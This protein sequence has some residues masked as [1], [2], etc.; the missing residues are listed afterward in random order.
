MDTHVA[1]LRGI[2][3]GGN[4][5]IAMAE[6]RMLITSLG[7]ADVQSYIQSGN[8]VFSGGPVAASE[9][10]A[11]VEATFGLR[12]AVVVRSAS[13]LQ[14]IIAACPFPA[15]DPKTLHVG[16]MSSAP[17]PDRVAALELERFL[18]EE[19]AVLGTESYLHLPSGMAR[20]KLPTYL[21]RQLK[22]PTT[23]RNWATV[24]KLAALA[25][26]SA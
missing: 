11:A 22:V 18:P 25:A 5:K 24:N 17:E 9:L 13:Q 10:E 23:L 4:N 3:V 15:A 1:L 16:F 19:F 8:V 20:T 12:I 7:Y 21:D 14:E 2:N 6:L 26:S